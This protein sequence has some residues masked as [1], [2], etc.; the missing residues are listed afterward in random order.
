MGAVTSP[1]R[2]VGPYTSSRTRLLV[3]NGTILF[4]S[5]Q[6]S[7]CPG[8]VNETAKCPVLGPLIAKLYEKGTWSPSVRS[9]PENKSQESA[10]IRVR[11]R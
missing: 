9:C 4:F 5:R 10:E 1:Y 6:L 11:C 7:R 3:L 2:Q 8:I